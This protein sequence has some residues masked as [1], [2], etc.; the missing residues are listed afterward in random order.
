MALT[1][2]LVS[3]TPN[4]LRY[5][6]EQDGEAG[7]A[8]TIPA[9]TLLADCIS[10]P[11]KEMPGIGSDIAGLTTALARRQLLGQGA[12]GGV[13]DLT[14]FQ[15]AACEIQPRGAST[16]FWAVDAD[17]DAVNAL[18]GELNITSGAASGEAILEVEFQHTLIR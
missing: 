2:T 11:L 16:E 8:V 15:H 10:G 14:N 6:L 5:L 17:V 1:A 13:T 12:A 7:A 9:A 18:R 3:Q 4:R